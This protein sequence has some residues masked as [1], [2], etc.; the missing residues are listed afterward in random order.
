MSPL[1]WSRP[2]V[3]LFLALALALGAAPAAAQSLLDA[4][5][6]GATVD[7]VD[8]RGRGLGSVGPG[9]FGT[10]VTPGDPGAAL[11]LSVP[12]VAF[13]MQS[14]WLKVDQVAGRT[15]VSGSRFPALGIAYPV[16]NWGI[17][18][19]TYGGVLDQRWTMVREEQLDLGTGGGGAS[20]TDEFVSDGGVAAARLGFARRVSPR[21]G[22]AVAVGS[23]TGTVVRGFTRSF[24][25]LDEG[26]SVA[27][28]RSAGKWGYSGVTATF[29]L[30]FDVA[31]VLR[32]AGTIT[33]AAS[34][35]AEPT[36]GTEG[37]A[38]KY[39]MPLEFRGGVSG[40]LAPGFSAVL[41]ASYADWAGTAADL[42]EATTAGAALTL[43]AGLEWEGLTALGRPLPLRFGW[44]R[45][46]LPFGFDGEIPVESTLAGGFG[47][48]LQRAG[49]L[50]L[51]QV[52]VGVERGSRSAGAVSENFWR[53]TVSLR[54]AGF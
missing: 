51:A 40:T 24:D 53:S 12:T 1:R 5:G 10:G 26:L 31:E 27:T 2:A 14:S 15:E 37:T 49:P 3:V 35:N 13:S 45:A 7:A 33:W 42:R 11:D 29:G 44:R 43:G 38:R 21:L 20:A 25:S 36:E 17:L 54:L 8:G 46:R 18:T 23:F 9:L 19:A 34:L 6:F 39:D 50:P 32:A 4:G 16:R 48:V 28:F 47:L 41:S 22:V 52:D 30:V